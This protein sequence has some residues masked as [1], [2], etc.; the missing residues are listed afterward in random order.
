MLLRRVSSN[1]DR[2]LRPASDSFSGMLNSAFML[3]AP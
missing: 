2:T 1:A 3:L